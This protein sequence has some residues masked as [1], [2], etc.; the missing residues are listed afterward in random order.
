MKSVSVLLF[1]GLMGMAGCGG[2]D[3]QNSTASE[4]VAAEGEASY[5]TCSFGLNCTSYLNSNQCLGETNGCSKCL[6]RN[7]GTDLICAKGL[8][9][10]CSGTV[11][12]CGDYKWAD[13]GSGDP[14][15]YLITTACVGVCCVQGGS[16]CYNHTGNCCAGLTCGTVGG[17]RVCC[18][19]RG[20]GCN[21]PAECCSNSCISGGC[22]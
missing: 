11:S 16:D 18:K 7:Q 9:T 12:W 1:A 3:N 20:Q 13:A 19:A 14:T 15:K 10:T 2:L 17:Y 6:W 21:D 8:G 22:I 5:Y 4:D